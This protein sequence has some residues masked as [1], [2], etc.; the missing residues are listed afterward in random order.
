M[1]ALIVLLFVAA[2][3]ALNA[4]YFSKQV[5]HQLNPT[6]TTDSVDAGQSNNSE[7]NRIRIPSL[8]ITAPIVTPDGTT[9]Q[10]YQEALKRGVVHYPGTA[11]VGTVGN[12]YIFGHSSD[13]VFKGGDYKT[14]FALLPQIQKDAEILVS[15]KDGNEFTYKVVESF[16]AN[17][18]DVK[19]LDQNTNGEKIL[20]LQT[21]Y[22][23]GTA[24]KRWIVKARITE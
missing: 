8:G 22:P 17:S 1:P 2:Y 10:L 12:A 11:D 7:P 6:E 3:V 9:E 24:L 20:T 5:G 4:S 18:N 13:F 15:D 23:I 21:S 19:L 16:V 14:V